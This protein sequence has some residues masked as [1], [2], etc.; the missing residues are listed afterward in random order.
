MW[1]VMQKRAIIVSKVM[2]MM[3]INQQPWWQKWLGSP[4][5]GDAW[6]AQSCSLEVL[7]L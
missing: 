2:K 1:R 7:R 3:M 6:G 4:H 5:Q